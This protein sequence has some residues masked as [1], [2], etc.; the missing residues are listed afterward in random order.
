MSSIKTLANKR[1]H[2]DQKITDAETRLDRMASDLEKLRAEC[3]PVL[4]RLNAAEDEFD[5]LRD[6]LESL[7]TERN[8]LAGEIRN[9][10]L[11]LPIAQACSELADSVLDA[12]VIL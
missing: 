4:H 3:L 12:E 8:W 10:V 6:R 1:R 7:R 11:G 5:E 9:E 2:V